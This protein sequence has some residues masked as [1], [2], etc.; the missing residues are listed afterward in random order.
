MTENE[1]EKGGENRENRGFHSF[2]SYGGDS[3]GAL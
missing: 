3:K 2:S 1:M